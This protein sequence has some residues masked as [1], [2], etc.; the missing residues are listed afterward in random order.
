MKIGV[1]IIEYSF[2]S[3]FKSYFMA[4]E[5]VVISFDEV[6]DVCEGNT[7]DNYILKVGTVKA[8]K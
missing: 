8:I 2:P 5:N 3:D 6:F 4:E 7:Y 1:N